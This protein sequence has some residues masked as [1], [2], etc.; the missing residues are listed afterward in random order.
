MGAIQTNQATFDF[1]REFG[2]VG[3]AP[4]NDALIP[5]DYEAFKMRGSG[6]GFGCETQLTSYGR[7]YIDLNHANLNQFA[8]QSVH[9]YL[10][11][12]ASSIFLRA[13][14][15]KA[16]LSPYLAGLQENGNASAHWIGLAWHFEPVGIPAMI[17]VDAP[18]L[19]GRV[20]SVN[21]AF[22]NTNWNMVSDPQGVVKNSAATIKIGEYGNQTA[23]YRI[24]SIWQ[25]TTRLDFF[26]LANPVYHVEGIGSQAVQYL[27]ATWAN[28]PALGQR[29]ELLVDTTGQSVMFKTGTPTWRVGVGFGIRQL[30]GTERPLML[31][32]SFRF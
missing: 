6:V 3:F 24:P 16:S 12:S 5:I 2:G 17:D 9:G 15:Q 14:Q 21:Q 30:N 11:A 22:I 25:V 20:V 19:W 29:F 31:N 23:S 28:W 32:Y 1:W 26:K 4:H 27:G 18:I 8:V 10:A 7:G 13:Q